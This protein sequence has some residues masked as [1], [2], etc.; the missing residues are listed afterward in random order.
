MRRLAL[1]AL[2]FLVLPLHAADPLPVVSD[3][4]GQPLGQNADAS[5]PGTRH[6]SASPLPGDTADT[7]PGRRRCPRR[8]EDPGARSTRT[9][10]SRS[11]INPESRVKVIRGPAEA[12]LQQNGY[13]VAVVKVVNE[14]TVKRASTPAHKPGRGRRPTTPGRLPNSSRIKD[15]EISAEA[16]SGRSPTQEAERR[17]QE[18]LPDLE[19]STKPP[20]TENAQRAEG[21]VRRPGSDLHR[22]GRQARGDHRVRRRPGDAGPRLPRRGAGPVRRQAGDPGEARR[23]PT[24]TA[25][26]PSAGS[27]SRDTAGPRLPA[28]GQAARPG[29]LLP[30]P[31]LPRRTAAPSCCRRANSSMIYGRGPEYKLEDA[32]AHRPGR[33]AKPDDRRQARSAGST[34]R[35]SASTAATTTSTPPAAPTTRARPRACC[36]Q[37][38]FL[39]VKG[40]G[41]NV[42][43]NLTWGPCYDFQ[44]QFFEPTSTS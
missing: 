16:A 43:C 32:D 19:M 3:V 5:A 17:V 26:R 28:A 21:R 1:L 11:A 18:P 23:S 15:K 42:G 40:E 22:R 38:M 34:R 35:T 20:M 7:A 9:S 37:D 30:G 39:H 41:L 25:S 6:S 12:T 27:R 24:T 36:P 31:G 29:L 8:Q 4:D 14:G 33:A 44:R 2:P 13:T 10:C